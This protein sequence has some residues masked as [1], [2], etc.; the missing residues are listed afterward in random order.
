MVEL[1]VDLVAAVNTAFSAAKA[2]FARRDDAA[3]SAAQSQI[4]GQLDEICSLYVTTARSH[5]ELERQN[6]KLE[7]R[8]V[9]L[10]ALLKDLENYELGT[11]ARG[12]QVY[13]QK[14]AQH[15][16]MHALY[17]CANCVTRGEKTFLQPRQ[18][19]TVLHCHIH[20][21]IPSDVEPPK[22]EPIPTAS[23]WKRQW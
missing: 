4:A 3:I 6:L 13:R 8:A 15:Q 22:V 12:G 16:G 14:G 11:T 5:A 23:P 21:A 10:E 20:G 18:G 2:A 19:G 1:S 7:Q 9:E 17:L